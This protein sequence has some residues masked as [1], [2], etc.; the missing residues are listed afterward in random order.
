MVWMVHH[1]WGRRSMRLRRYLQLRLCVGGRRD[2][3]V[4]R[5]AE[6]VRFTSLVCVYAGPQVRILGLVL[7]C[8][9]EAEVRRRWRL[10]LLLLLLLFKLETP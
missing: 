3:W 4:R 10:A 1:G 2:L 8:P 7:V 5:V 6:R 9:C